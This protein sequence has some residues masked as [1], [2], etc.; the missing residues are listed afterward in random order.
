MKKIIV[1]LAAASLLLASCNGDTCSCSTKVYDG[2]GNK[3]SELNDV[4][5]PKPE[6]KTCNDVAKS[7]SKD[8]GDLG[9][10]VV[11]CKT[12]QSEDVK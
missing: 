1:A 10:T 6:D 7:L 4:K 3:K 12:V 11:T 5:S 2:Q 9:K 8:L